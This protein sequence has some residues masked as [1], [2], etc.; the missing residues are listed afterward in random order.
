M[1]WGLIFISTNGL[2]YKCISMK[3]WN[4]VD[5]GNGW[6]RAN[7]NIIVYF[8]HHQDIRQT[9]VAYARRPTRP[10]SAWLSI[11]VCTRDG[12]N[13]TV[14]CVTRVSW[15][16]LDCADTWTHNTREINHLHVHFVTKHIHI[17]MFWRI[18][19]LLHTKHLC[20]ITT[21]SKQ[22][23]AALYPIVYSLWLYPIVYLLQV[24]LKL[25]LFRPFNSSSLSTKPNPT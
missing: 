8:R 14:Q 25:P 19:S 17:N 12:I 11:F 13:I 5:D 10:N 23:S 7:I 9:C 3:C 15:I 18:I 21:E 2:R 16:R 22:L 20:N 4:M 1:F 6:M 24:S